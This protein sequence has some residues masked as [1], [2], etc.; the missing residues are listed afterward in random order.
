MSERLLFYLL[1]LIWKGQSDQLQNVVVVEVASQPDWK[2]K[3]RPSSTRKS[4]DSKTASQ[5]VGDRGLK[6]DFRN[7]NKN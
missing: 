6:I 4:E 2:E 3:G 5:S 7:L 1:I